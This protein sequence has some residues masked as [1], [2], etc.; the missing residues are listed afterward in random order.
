MTT[1]KDKRSFKG[2]PGHF[3]PEQEHA[4]ATFKVNLEKAGLYTPATDTSKASHDDATLA[5]VS[6][7]LS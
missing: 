4:F 1:S 2:H 6:A 3:T 5:Y 7:F